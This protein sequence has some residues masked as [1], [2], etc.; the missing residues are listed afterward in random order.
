MQAASGIVHSV[1]PCTNWSNVRRFFSGKTT[2]IWYPPSYCNTTSTSPG[3]VR[4]VKGI[5]NE[6]LTYPSEKSFPDIDAS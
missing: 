3:G 6:M 4:E 5:D 1:V 2:A